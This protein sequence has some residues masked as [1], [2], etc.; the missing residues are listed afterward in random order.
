VVWKRLEYRNIVPL[1]GITP[2]PLQ[3]ISEWTPDGYL[4]KKHPGADR[5]GLASTPAAVFDHTLT[6]ATSYPMSLKV[7]T[8]STPAA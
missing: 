4:I 2:N 1:R 6:P 7:F 3:L 5:L 8:F